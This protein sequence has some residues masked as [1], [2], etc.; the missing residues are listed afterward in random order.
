MRARKVGLS[1]LF[2]TLGLGLSSWVTRTPAIRD[3]VEASTAE[4]GLVLFG[5]S[6]GSMIGL[7]LSGPFVSRLGARR[8][9]VGSVSILALGMPLVGIGSA[10]G[11]AIVV[12]LGLAIFGFGVGGADI[13]LNVD[14]ADVERRTR[15][16]F[17][18]YMHGFFSV[19]TVLGAIS[20]IVFTAT[21][22]PVFWHMMIIGAAAIAALGF[23]IRT[24]P[25]AT[26]KIERTRGAKR[27]NAPRLWRDSRLLMIGLIVLAMALVEG[28][29]HDWLPLILVDGHG[30]T[31]A[32][33]SAIYALFTTGMA[34]GRFV[35]GPIVER[36]GR[37]AVLAAS[38]VAAA[39]GLLAVAFIDHQASVI[40]AVFFWGL[41]AS[42][43]FPVAISAAGDAE[44]GATARVSLVATLG[45][46]AFLVGPPI[47]GVLGDAITLRLAILL[48]T[49]LALL[50]LPLIRATRPTTPTVRTV[51]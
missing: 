32:A 18:P 5:L 17:L 40:V 10:V 28:T 36:I 41:G 16:S 39:A 50:T 33:S 47:L 2:L 31:A 43:G 42:L 45:Y 27:E 9:V 25:P 14:G 13:A 49:L 24:L 3:A 46:I 51:P 4:M 8:V 38:A 35:G 22:F 7:L 21:E 12:A 48:P 20:G 37:V 30:F 15:R 44:E 11:S 1:A 6:G 34:V 26:G 23:A 19:G 29:A